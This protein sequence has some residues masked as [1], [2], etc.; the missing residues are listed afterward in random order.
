MENQNMNQNQAPNPYNNGQPVVQVNMPPQQKT[1]GLAI[2]SMVLGII[3]LCCSCFGWIGIICGVLAVIMSGIALAG[4]KAGKGMAVAGLVCGIIAL[5]PSII[6]IATVG[7][8]ISA[9]S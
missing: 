5:I 1:S 9:F 4:H 7:S 3:S 2:A 8:I 6:V